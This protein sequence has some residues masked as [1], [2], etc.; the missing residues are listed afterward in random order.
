MKKITLSIYIGLCAYI[1]LAQSSLQGVVADEQHAPLTGAHLLLKETGAGQIADAT[2]KFLFTNLK[3][4]TYTVVASFIGYETKTE[5]IQVEGATR[6]LLVLTPGALQLSDVVVTSAPDRPV[7]TLSQVDIKLRPVNTSQDVLRM[8]PGLF[9]AQHAG[10]GKAEQIFL[11]GFDCDHGTDIAVD[12]DGVPVNMVSHA[13]GQGYADLHFLMPELI[14]YA[15]FDKGPY[16]ANKGDLNTAGYVSFQTRRLLDRSFVKMEAGSFNSGRIAVGVNVSRTAKSSAFIASEYFKSDGFF[17]NNQDF[18]RFNLH[19][20]FNTQ[21]SA[22]TQLSAVFTTFSSGWNA[23]G[24]IPDRAVDEGIISRFGSLDPTEGGNTGRT[25]MYVKLWRD[26]KNGGSWESQL[27]A[28]RYDFSLFSNF[29]FFLH[30]PVN[31]DQINQKD[32]RWI[33]GYLTRYQQ[34]GTLFGKKWK[35]DLGAGGRMDDIGDIELN[36]TVKRTFLAHTTFGS[37]RELNMNAY[38]SG[39]LSIT[40]EFSVNAALRLDYF[41]FNYNDALTTTQRPAVGTAIVSPKLNFNYQVNPNVSLFVRT[42]SGFHSNDVRA[43]VAQDGKDILPRA[44]SM[45]VG[46]DVKVTPRLFVHAALWRMNLDQEF[47]YVGDEGVVEPSG[48]TTREGMDVSARWQLNSWLF[49]DVD[50]NFTRPRLDDAPDGQNYIPLAPVVSSVAGLSVRRGNGLNGSLRYRYLSDRPANE[51]NTLVAR[52]YFITDAI[53]NYTQRS[54]EVGL[55]AEN[56]F[57]VQWKE[58]QFDTLSRLRN[59]AAPVDEI[60]FT[61][62]TPFSLRLRVTKYF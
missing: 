17:V 40:D 28:V 4:G 26:L 36:H 16:F 2:G 12:M 62:G 25:N 1:S 60:H 24:Q 39:T 5:T 54:W 29:T 30:D 48:K 45:D 10:G 33:Y 35:T 49:A 42:G 51:D 32:S 59:E 58:A 3:A 61:P 55:S 41:H 7:N 15:D 6:L 57:D 37:A 20:R 8:V 56:I 46:A 23:S 27:Y 14:S 22:R 18:T 50:A 21:L 38:A 19:S 13:H 31:G 53:V 43:V 44:Y 34:A 52:G 11:R 47:V 9:I